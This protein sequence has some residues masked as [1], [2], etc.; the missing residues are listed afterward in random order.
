MKSALSLAAVLLLASVPASSVA[1]DTDE[2]SAMAQAESG[3]PSLNAE[4]QRAAGIV[5]AHPVAAELARRDDALGLVLDPTDLITAAAAA[6][7]AAAAA[8]AATAEVDRVRGLYKAGAGAS[9]KALE[10]AQAEQA[11]TRAES[12]AATAKFA[13]RWRPVVAL[14]AAARQKLIDAAAAGKSLLVRADLPNRHILGRLPD[15]ALL[16]VDG[17]SVPGTVLGT[18][19]HSGEDVQGV[20]VLVEVRGP[21]AGLGPGARFPVALL[22]AKHSGVLVPRDAVLFDDDGALVYKQLAPK[23]GDKD[24]VYSPVRIKLLQ[25]QGD[26]WLVDGIDDD[27][28]VVV[29][30]AGVLW[31]LQGIVGHAAGDI[32]DND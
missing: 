14:P 13:S 25:A 29:H 21:P 16:D 20:G 9:L 10:T 28:S 7:A 32:D 24:T 8:H 26:S 2:Y 12:E 6:D 27:D 4:Q 31:S 15:R 17:V 18:L 3:P 1:A 5:V 11:R 23:S 22:G 19:A 30:G